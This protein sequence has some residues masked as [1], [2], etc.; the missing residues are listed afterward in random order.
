MNSF[1]IMILGLEAVSCCFR[2]DGIRT[3]SFGGKLSD[4]GDH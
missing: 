2:F 4:Y 3:I 1:V